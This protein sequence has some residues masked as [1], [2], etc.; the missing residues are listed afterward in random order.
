M[1][2]RAFA[3]L[4][5]TL[6]WAP[7]A[8]LRAASEPVKGGLVPSAVLERY[9]ASLAALKHPKAVTFDYSVEQLGLR[10]MEQTHHV[11]RSGRNERDETLVVDGLQLPRPSVRIIANRTYRYDIGAVAPTP[12]TYSFTYSGIVLDGDDLAY[13]FRTEPHVPASF[14]VSEIELDAHTFL[15]KIV[16]FKIAGYGARGSGELLY[17]PSDVYWVVREAKVN[18]HLTSGTLAHERITWSNYQFPAGL[19]P[20]TFEAPRPTTVLDPEAL[21]SPTPAPDSGQ[22]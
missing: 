13:V 3:L 9:A 15:P 14:A 8:A 22:P 4:L 18:A 19:P 11:Y 10:N 17:G 12:A 1:R 21:A 20:S 7:S 2:R 5:A 6:F 16:R